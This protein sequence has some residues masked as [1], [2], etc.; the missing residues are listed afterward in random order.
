MLLHQHR[1]M[2]M[3]LQ[4]RYFGTIYADFASKIE[5]LAHL[6]DAHPGEQ[7]RFNESVVR[8]LLEEFLPKRYSFGTGFV[9][10]S[11]GQQSRQCD[12]I[13]YDKH[14]TISMFGRT[15]PL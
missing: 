4:E 7:G 6:V 2:K 14:S 1:G 9:I 11:T 8:E 10:D 15:G 3:T 5:I 12:I 13:I